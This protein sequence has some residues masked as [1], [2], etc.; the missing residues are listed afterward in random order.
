[1][2]NWAAAEGAGV[3]RESARYSGQGVVGL[4]GEA[5][6]IAEADVTVHLEG[7]PSRRATISVGDL[8]IFASMG[9]SSEPVMVVGLDVLGRDRLVVCAQG[10]AGSAGSGGGQIWIPSG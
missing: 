6:P 5:I 7:G 8:P 10:G 9:L 1:M 3:T 4:A 2:A